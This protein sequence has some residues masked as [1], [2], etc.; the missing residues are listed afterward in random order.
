MA[1]FEEFKQ[2]VLTADSRSLVEQLS[3]DVKQPLGTAHNLIHI[4]AMM[5]QPSEAMQQ[6]IE[7]GELNADEMLEQ[8]TAL[9]GQAFDCLDYY[10]QILNE[11]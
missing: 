3:R 7:S 8:L 5:Q 4:L 2:F 10:R 1:E 6:K 9:I 11:E